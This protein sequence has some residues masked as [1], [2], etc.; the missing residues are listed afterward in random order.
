MSEVM[1]TMFHSHRKKNAAKSRV[2]SCWGDLFDEGM[3]AVNMEDRQNSVGESCQRHS[4]W[5]TKVGGQVLWSRE[6][7]VSLSCC[8]VMEKA[9][10]LLADQILLEQRK[11]FDGAEND[12]VGED[13]GVE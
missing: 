3:K 7:V 10:Q 12:G 6:R 5:Y 9:H 8:D 13:G 2:N 1:V 4:K 11:I